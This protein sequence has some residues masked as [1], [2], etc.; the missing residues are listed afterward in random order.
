MADGVDDLLFVRDKVSF[1]GSSPASS[2]ML[3]EPAV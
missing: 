1:E 2:E 3:K